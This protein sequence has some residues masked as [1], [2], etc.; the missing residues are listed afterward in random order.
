MT[1]LKLSY[2]KEIIII[3]SENTEK[4][5]KYLKNQNLFKIKTKSNLRTNYNYIREASK[6]LA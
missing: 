4:N 3:C 2:K 1:T 6:V 5:D